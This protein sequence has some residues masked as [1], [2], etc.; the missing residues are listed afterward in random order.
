MVRALTDPYMRWYEYWAMIPEVLIIAAGIRFSTRPLTPASPLVAMQ[1]LYSAHAS[2]LLLGFASSLTRT[3]ALTIVAL[4]GYG[5][6]VVRL[7][8]DTKST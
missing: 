8:R 6:D 5:I 1:C 2:L 4:I 3:A 7:V